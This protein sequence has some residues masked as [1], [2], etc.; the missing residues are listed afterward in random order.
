MVWQVAAGPVVQGIFG[1]AVRG[2]LGAGGDTLSPRLRGFFSDVKAASIAQTP[3]INPLP[4]SPPG[5]PTGGDVFQDLLKKPGTIGTGPTPDSFED[6][7]RRPRS[8]PRPPPSDFEELL[9]RKPYRAARGSLAAALARASVLIGGLF[10]PSTLG[11]SDLGYKAPKTKTGR[12]GPPRRPKLRT[13]TRD[14]ELPPPPFG[15]TIPD[16]LPPRDAPSRDTRP[17]PQTRP[18][19]LPSPTSPKARPQPR[20]GRAPTAAPLGRSNP[21]PAFLAFPFFSPG[22][23]R[24]PLPAPLSFSPSPL[25]ANDPIYRDPISD[26]GLTAPLPAGLTFPTPLPGPSDPCSCPPKGSR[27]RRKRKPRTVCYRGEYV[28]K[29]NGLTKFRK[30]KIPCQ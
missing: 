7:I 15:Q 13:R 25:T 3:G 12:K 14:R 16:R 4:S 2:I 26:R 5:L 27:T 29:A 28:E 19:I 18:A 10:Y 21:N 11:D 9:K 17:R 30:R 8:A 23:R 24:A 1:T 6:L 22:S 20:P